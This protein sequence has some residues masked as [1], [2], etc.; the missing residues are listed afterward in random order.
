MPASYYIFRSIAALAATLLVSLA[1]MLSVGGGR[2]THD[3]I[4]YYRA[5]VCRRHICCRLFAFD[6]DHWNNFFGGRLFQ[7]LLYAFTPACFSL[8]KLI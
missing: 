8:N 4:Y 3:R 2:T 7:T 6:G 1:M 5:P